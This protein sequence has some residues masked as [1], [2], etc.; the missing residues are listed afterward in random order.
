MR[1]YDNEKTSGAELV[2]GEKVT[3]YTTGG[4][5]F[6][7]KKIEGRHSAVDRRPDD[8]GW[9]PG[10]VSGYDYIPKGGRRVRGIMTYYSPTIL[11]ARGWGLPELRGNFSRPVVNAEGTCATSTGR[12]M[13]CSPGWAAE[14]AEDTDGVSFALEV[15]PHWKE[16]AA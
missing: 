9:R 3:I 1:E 10:A 2:P 5:G 16:A 12:H 6:G 14:L 15:R 4:G 13:S 8:M 11:V 7:W